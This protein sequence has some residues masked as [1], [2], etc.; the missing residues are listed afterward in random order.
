MSKHWIQ[1][2][3]VAIDDTTGALHVQAGMD[4]AGKPDILT[5]NAGT[6]SYAAPA[7]GSVTHA[8][9][10]LFV[11]VGA[12]G[13]LLSVADVAGQEKPYLVPANCI[14][15]ITIAGGIP[16][17]AAITARNL[18]AAAFAGLVVEVR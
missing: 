14:R 17:G 8:A 18:S 1:S 15:E 9:S 13:A 10:V 11:T 6:A 7:S 5:W 4:G 2:A 12:G 3:S 16:A